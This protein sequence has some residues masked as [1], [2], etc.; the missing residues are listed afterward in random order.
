MRDLRLSMVSGRDFSPALFSFCIVV[1]FPHTA[2]HSALSLSN[3]VS[4]MPACLLGQNVD[5]V[6]ETEAI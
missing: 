3:R 4:P 1:L 5:E 2:F 6:K